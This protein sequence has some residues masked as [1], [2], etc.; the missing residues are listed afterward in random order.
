MGHNI[1]DDGVF[2]MLWEDFVQYFV[3]VDIC[4][5]NDNAHYYYHADNF[6]KNKPICYDLQTSGGELNLI[7]SQVSKRQASISNPNAK[8]S[9]ITFVLASQSPGNN[10]L[11]Y[12]YVDSKF[13]THYSQLYMNLPQ[14]ASGK[15]V[16]CVFIEHSKS[17]EST[18]SIYSESDISFLPSTNCLPED[19]L[20]KV[21]LDHARK[22]V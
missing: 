10:G 9:D 8:M 18:V 2:F 3:I 5:I 20:H 7:A 11:E 21:F 1:G 19:F 6:Q 15:Y 12:Q 13:G 22:N 4:Y 14:L 16:L 17:T